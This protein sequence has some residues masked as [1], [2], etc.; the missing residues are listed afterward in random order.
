MEVTVKARHVYRI[1]ARWQDG[2]NLVQ[3]WDET[4]GAEKRVL[5]MQFHF[6]REKIPS[7]PRESLIGHK[8]T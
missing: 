4:D 3:F 8:N 6:G 7:A 5:V 1:T 2:H